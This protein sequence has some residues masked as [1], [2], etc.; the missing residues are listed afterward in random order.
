M[1]DSRI[2]KDII[3][4]IGTCPKCSS[5]VCFDHNVDDRRGLSHLLKLSCSNCKCKWHKIFWTSN[6]VDNTVAVDRGR[7]RCEINTR[8]IIA[9][10]EIG[11]SFE[12]MKTCGFLNIPPPMTQKS[13]SELQIII[14]SRHIMSLL[15]LIWKM[16]LLNYVAVLTV[17]LT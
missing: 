11:K 6:E 12:S 4:T 2:L 9:F 7:K 15:V 3:D 14:L 1:I 5:K 17:L 16:L 10:R 8:A 13:F